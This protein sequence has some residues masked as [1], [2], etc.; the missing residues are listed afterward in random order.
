LIDSKQPSDRPKYRIGV[1]TSSRADYGIY[2][3]LLSLMKDDDQVDLHLIVFGTHLMKKFGSTV[4]LIE[5]DNSGLVLKVY[6]MPEKDDVSSVSSGYGELAKQFSDFWSEHSFDYVLCLGDR[7]EMSAAIQ[8]SIPFEVKLAHLHGGETT[9]GATDNIYRH[10]ISLAAKL[11]F[12]A[13]PSFKNRVAEITGSDDNVHCVGALSLSELEDMNLPSWEDICKEFSIPDSPFILMTL[14][15]ETVGAEK[16]VQFAKEAAKAIEALTQQW[17]FVVTMPNADVQGSVYREMLIELQKNNPNKVHLIEN[18][19]KEKYF[20]AMKASEFLLGNT[21]S[22]ILEAASFG[23][24]VVNI[25][26]RQKGRLQS[27]NVLNASFNAAEIIQCV[28]KVS[29]MGEYQG[30][31]VYYRKNTASKILNILKSAKL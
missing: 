24:Y 31:N 9:L 20:A 7:F 14:H 11:H 12:V 25:G 1:L 4:N 27:P 10:Q 3:P 21:S 22:G 8:A 6:G 26:D 23:K 30:A 18:F 28:I 13:A 15:P 5:I 29:E 2:K 16:N 17:Y 19:G